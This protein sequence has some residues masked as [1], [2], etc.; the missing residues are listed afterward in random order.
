MLRNELSICDCQCSIVSR[1]R[2]LV[3]DE[4][5]YNEVLTVVSTLSVLLGAGLVWDE[6]KRRCGSESEAL[7]K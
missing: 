7:E 3:S 1:E 2:A 4:T 6:A 5:V